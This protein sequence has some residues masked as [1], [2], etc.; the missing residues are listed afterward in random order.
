[1]HSLPKKL[2]QKVFR[3]WIGGRKD[4]R[5]IYYVDKNNFYILGIFVTLQSRASFS[6][7]TSNWLDRVET[8][9][10]DFEDEQYGKFSIIDTEKEI[11]K[12]QYL[13]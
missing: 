4:F 8:I 2:K 13:R 1:M 6:Y 11:R 5:F 9:V 3:L 12:L 10:T 7:E